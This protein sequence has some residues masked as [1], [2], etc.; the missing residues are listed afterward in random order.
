MRNQ[1]IEMIIQSRRMAQRRRSKY[2]TPEDLKR[3]FGRTK[4]ML[5]PMRNDPSY[6]VN[7]GHGI[8]PETPVAS[9]RAFIDTV[10]E[11]DA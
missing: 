2:F 10:R 3:T 8:L 1:V 4:D 6:I 11:A 7:L 9:V 5:E